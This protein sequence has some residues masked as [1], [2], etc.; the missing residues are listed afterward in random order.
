[1]R[2]HVFATLLAV[3]SLSCTAIAEE[4]PDP[5][6]DL[7]QGSYTAQTQS[8]SGIL[9]VYWHEQKVKLAMNS[10]AASQ[11][12]LYRNSPNPKAIEHASSDMKFV[13]L[14]WQGSNT[15]L[16]QTLSQEFGE[17]TAP[18]WKKRHG[19]LNLPATVAIKNFQLYD[20]ACDQYYFQADVVGIKRDSHSKVAPIYSEL[21]ANGIQMEQYLVSAPDGYANLRKAPNVNAAIQQRL[22]NKTLVLELDKQG[23]W[24]QVQVLEH[25][26]IGAIGFVHQSQVI[27]MD[28]E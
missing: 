7:K 23:K 28:G 24:I 3:S 1:M 15:Q 18:F 12:Q 10:D 19:I 11:R 14:N 4:V 5:L 16:K 26:R 25:G 22:N 21:C 9:S 8:I 17:V 27:L 2:A 6:A 20:A 13:D